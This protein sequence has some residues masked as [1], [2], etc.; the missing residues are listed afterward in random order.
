MAV[1]LKRA[2]ILGVGA[3]DGMESS[4]HHPVGRKS[5]FNLSESIVH[6]LVH[7]VVDDLA[8]IPELLRVLLDESEHCHK[9]HVPMILA[10]G[11]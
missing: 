9:V 1:Q 5:G 2:A 11:T 7:N 10:F 6:A 8:K 3:G 4:F